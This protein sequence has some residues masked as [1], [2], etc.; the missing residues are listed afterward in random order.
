MK[1]DPKVA[2]WKVVRSAL[3]AALALLLSSGGLDAFFN[4]LSTGIGTVGIP[5]YLIP[6]I[7]GL[8]TL[9][10]N[11]VKQYLASKVVPVP[12]PPPTL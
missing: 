4:S 7:A 9:I 12:D 1:F 10:R 5:I 6:I 2:A 3:L 11:W 8:I